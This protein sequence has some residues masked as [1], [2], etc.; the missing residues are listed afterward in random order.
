M[1]HLAGA[2][3]GYYVLLVEKPENQLGMHDLDVKL[4]RGKGTVLARTGYEGQ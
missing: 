3:A 4:T 1:Q 2:L